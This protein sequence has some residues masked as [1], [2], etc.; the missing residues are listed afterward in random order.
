VPL[1]PADNMKAAEDFLLVVLHGHI[2][3]AADT[4]ISDSNPIDVL[5]LSEKIVDQYV[6]IAIPSSSSP[7]AAT[8]TATDKVCIYAMEVL[9]LGL[10]WHNFHDST[11]EGDGDQILRNWK[12]N[13]LVLKAARRKNYSIKL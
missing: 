1:D 12:F 11:K 7:S 9:T 8:K 4:I 3:A 10:L 6:K 5:S 13:L 2:I